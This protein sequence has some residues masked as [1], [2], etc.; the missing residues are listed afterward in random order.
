[1][2]A[3]TK[4]EIPYKPRYP[5]VHDKLAAHRFSVLVAH[6][7]FGKTVLVVNHLIR[8][9]LLSGCPRGSYGYVAPFRNQAKLVAWD[10]LKHYTAPVPGRTV[11]ESELSI[12]LPSNGGGAKIR[13]FGADN[14]DALRGLYFDGVV[15]DEVAQMK[16]EVWEEILQPAL[17]DRRGWAV[18]IGTPKGINLFSELYHRAC[19]AG[20]GGDWCAMS[21]PVTATE[22]LPPEEVE[23]LR[24]ELSDNAWRQEMLCDFAASSDDVL[25]PLSL[26]EA[27]QRRAWREA[28][29]RFSPLV[30]GVDVAR[31]GDDC[32]V[33]CARQGLVAFA[34]VLLRKQDNMAV[35]DRVAQEARERKA[36]AVFIDAGAGAG[37]IDRLRQ[38]GQ[39]V[40][41]VHFGGRPMRPDR[42]VNR[43]M[44]MWQL[45]RD[46]LASGGALPPDEA[47]K[48]ELA[49]PTYSFDSRG[50]LR[51][52]AKEKV[53]ERL[54]RSPDRADALALTFAAPVAAPDLAAQAAEGGA[55][56]DPLAW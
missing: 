26:V 9:A 50:L 35:A 1:M 18:F 4:V 3:L 34:P 22:A 37:V 49:A 20:E 7:R 12:G 40:T 56:Y 13:I 15:L 47:L 28:E 55:A 23:R 41:E 25:I 16:P 46:W 32:S 38:L 51:L 54:L 8:Q 53:K 30:L 24:L 2:A 45:L 42:F 31:F 10:Y 11:N 27:A 52:E 43:R 21:Y 33:I 44:E 6:R 48:A 19:A 14:P 36:A 17:A 5:E 39:R 29:Y